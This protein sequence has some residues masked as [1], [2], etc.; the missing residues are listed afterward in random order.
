MQQDG[1]AVPLQRQ[2]PLI[3]HAPPA[4]APVDPRPGRHGPAGWRLPGRQG[5]GGRVGSAEAGQI[6]G[7]GRQ[8]KQGQ[9]GHA[10][11]RPAGRPGQMASLGGG[12]V[13]PP[14]VAY[15]EKEQDH[16]A[17]PDPAVDQMVDPG[18]QGHAGIMAEKDDEGGAQSVG[19]HGREDADQ[20]ESQPLPGGLVGQVGVKPTQD[21][22]G[23]EVADAGAGFHHA[24]LSGG[25]DEEIAFLVDRD[26]E[27]A[28]G[29]DGEVG[30][31][32]DHGF[33]EGIPGGHHEVKVEQGEEQGAGQGAAVEPP[34]RRHQHRGQGIVF[35]HQGPG[36][37]A[38]QP[39]EAGG[40]HH[41]QG[42]GIRSR[43]QVGQD[44]AAAPDQPG[45]DGQDDVAVGVGFGTVPDR[46]H[47]GSRRFQQQDGPTPDQS[48]GCQEG[49][50][51]RAAHS[52]PPSAR[53]ASTPARLAGQV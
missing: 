40:G 50:G 30:G 7:E 52:W 31:E 37:T 49:D 23:K 27:Q 36:Q 29:P 10:P 15:P 46:H 13:F 51:R 48:Q 24:P 16:H 8:A 6:G 4:W 43:V 34:H 22:G 44:M 28:H 19:R 21:Q 20:A 14:A 2:G 33:D 53:R 26:A 17:K 11:G 47:A 25:Q 39:E 9:H 3:I 38:G 45:N 1:G 35:H 12:R 42:G 5:R 32:A 41:G 18:G